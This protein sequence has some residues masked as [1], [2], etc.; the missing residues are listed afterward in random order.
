MTQCSEQ[1]LLLSSLD[2]RCHRPGT[3]GPCQPGEWFGLDELIRAL[4]IVWVKDNSN[5]HKLALEDGRALPSKAA[6]DCLK[7]YFN[8]WKKKAPSTVLRPEFGGPA[9]NGP[10]EDKV[11]V[12]TFI[13]NAPRN[14]NGKRHG[15][16]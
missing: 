4:E 6:H 9:A 3:Q 13:T 8:K 2:G 15:V 5:V 11:P 7:A 10:Q 1:S 12:L 16:M 14:C